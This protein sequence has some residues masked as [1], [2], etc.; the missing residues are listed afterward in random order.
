MAWMRVVLIGW[1]D[2]RAGMAPSETFT[3]GGGW[4]EDVR[5]RNAG[6]TLGL[7]GWDK[8]TPV[9]AAFQEGHNVFK[10]SGM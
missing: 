8:A 9:V 1:V 7:V 3:A 4:A 5:Q 2:D 10:E 6:L